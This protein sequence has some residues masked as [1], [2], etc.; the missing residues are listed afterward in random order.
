METHDLCGGGR[1]WRRTWRGWR[2]CTCGSCWRT[3]HGMRG[4]NAFLK[5]RQF[6]EY[7]A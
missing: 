2:A 7:C 3:R 4:W 6:G 5:S 1:R